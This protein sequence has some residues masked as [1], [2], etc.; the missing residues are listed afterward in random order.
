MWGGLQVLVVISSVILMFLY[1][2]VFKNDK[3]LFWAFTVVLVILII[4]KFV[5][6]MKTDGA[7]LVGNLL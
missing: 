6:L 2:S 5:D 4:Y 7:H 1:N 3:R